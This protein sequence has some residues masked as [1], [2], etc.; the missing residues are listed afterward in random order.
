MKKSYLVY[1]GFLVVIVIVMI[2]SAVIQDHRTKKAQVRDSAVKTLSAAGAT[3]VD[4]SYVPPL[5]SNDELL[6]G[7]EDVDLSGI[8][9]ISDAIPQ[10]KDSDVDGEYLFTTVAN[11]LLK[12]AKFNIVSTKV[13]GNDAEVKVHIYYEDRQ[14]ELVLEY[15]YYDGEWMLSNTMEAINSLQVDGKDYDELESAAYDKIVK[16]VGF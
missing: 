15:F 9:D 14:G 13:R 3:E 7:G 10:M 8:P 11:K 16:E 12:N 6:H 5:P 4:D 1:S 2:V